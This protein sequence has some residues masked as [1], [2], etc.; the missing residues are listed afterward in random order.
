MAMGL[1]DLRRLAAWIERSRLSGVVWTFLTLS[2]VGLLLAEWVFRGLHVP[3]ATWVVNT[4]PMVALGGALACFI[5]LGWP[6]ADRLFSGRFL[7][8]SGRIS[9]SLYLVHEPVAVSIAGLV[10]PGTI[11]A[12]ITVVLTCAISV[13]LAV[14][15]HRYVE[16]PC[17]RWSR[18]LGKGVDRFLGPRG[19][20]REWN[21]ATVTAPP[22]VAAAPHR[23]R[24]TPRPASPAEVGGLVD[25]R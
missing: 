16:A 14:L 7:Q 3:T 9:F 15:L 10:T 6:A 2:S 13:A 12:L 1:D 20:H 17:Q 21:G 23:P 18:D 22:H 4:P 11:G 8:W 25:A 5:V 24:I 19:R